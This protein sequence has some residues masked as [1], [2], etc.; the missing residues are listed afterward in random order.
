MIGRSLERR[1]K[2]GV[3]VRVDEDAKEEDGVSPNK[4]GIGRGKPGRMDV[5]SDHELKNLA[6]IQKEAD[7]V[8]IEVDQDRLDLHTEK[9]KRETRDR[10]DER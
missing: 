6:A 10:M 5:E 8:R 1:K 9:T 4:N 7:I 2:H 3:E